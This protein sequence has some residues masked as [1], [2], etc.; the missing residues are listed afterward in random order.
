MATGVALL[1]KPVDAV[2][3]NKAV[4]VV[5]AGTPERLELAEARVAVPETC[6]CEAAAAPNLPSSARAAERTADPGR[7]VAAAPANE[8]DEE[9]VVVAC[10]VPD[11]VALSSQ[12]PAKLAAI[13]DKAAPGT[14][15]AVS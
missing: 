1:G 9:E 15:R 13:D 7:S 4:V 12:G 2:S 10:P 5:V 8:A 14:G 6:T 11:A 3:E